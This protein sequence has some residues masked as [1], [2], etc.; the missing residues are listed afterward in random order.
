MIGK[1]AKDETPVSVNK[2]R[3]ILEE[4]KAKRELTYEQQQAY[5]HAKKAV[6][7]KESAET[8]MLKSLEELEV[9]RKAA[10]KIVDVMPKVPMTL[11]QILMHENKTFNDEEIGRILAIVKE[12]S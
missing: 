10:I 4:R 8:K 1:A 11:R 12:N 5:D 6:E 9:S 2:A 7:V 3:E